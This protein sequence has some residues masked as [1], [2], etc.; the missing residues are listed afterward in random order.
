M[1]GL[2][3]SSYFV[4]LVFLKNIIQLFHRMSLNLGLAGGAL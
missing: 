1:K 3:L 2:S 4:I